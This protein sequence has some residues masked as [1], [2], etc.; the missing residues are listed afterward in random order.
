[1]AQQNEFLQAA[2][3][4]LKKETKDVSGSKEKAMAAAVGAA[5]ADFCVQ[6]PEFAQAIVQGGTFKDCMAAV[7]KGVGTSISDSEAFAKAARFYF[8]GSRVRVMMQIDLIGDAEDGADEQCSPLRN[9]E[10]GKGKEKALVVNLADF[11]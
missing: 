5:L 8:P 4:R 6:E 1:M 7:A 10:D 9:Q 2:L 11:F 3:E